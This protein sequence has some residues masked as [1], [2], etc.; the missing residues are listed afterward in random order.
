MNEL[1]SEYGAGLYSLASEE[2]ISSDILDEIRALVPLITPEYTRLLIDPDIPKEERTG[3]IRSA[4]SGHVNDYL[5]SFMM[6]LTE[7]S[8]A[9]EIVPAFR[10][11]ERLYYESEGIERVTAESAVPL[12]SVQKAGLER[13]LAAHIGGRVEV[14]YVVNPALLGGMK[15]SWGSRLIDDSISSKLKET[16]ARLAEA[17]V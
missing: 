13:K 1:I 5:V 2:G 9:T 7:R 11:Y 3:F 14:T 4:F 16:G 15:I 10:E 8:L 12:S 17:I 6:L